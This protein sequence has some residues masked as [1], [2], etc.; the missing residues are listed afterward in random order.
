M[1]YI[2][3]GPEQARRAKRI[4]A[5]LESYL[6][7]TEVHTVE[8]LPK[9]TS[10]DTLIILPGTSGELHLSEGAIFW[11]ETAFGENEQALLL[12][13][14]DL[15]IAQRSVA[16]A[17]CSLAEDQTVHRLCAPETFSDDRNAKGEGDPCPDE[18]VAEEGWEA[19]E[20][21]LR[22]RLRSGSL[23]WRMSTTP[24]WLLFSADLVLILYS[25][26]GDK[27]FFTAFLSEKAQMDHFLQTL[28]LYGCILPL[29]GYFSLHTHNVLLRIRGKQR[30][31]F[32]LLATVG[33]LS[34]A[35][36]YIPEFRAILHSESSV[37]DIIFAAWL[38]SRPTA[39]TLAIHL[40]TEETDQN[41]VC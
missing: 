6:Y 29:F 10:A 27:H 4:H 39:A 18:N 24:I 23:P 37:Y 26:I 22:A 7:K 12:A 21:A 5:F 20:R 40:L 25:L 36:A 9:K 1:I 38:I 13:E 28:C 19:R 3:H 35:A 33:V 2:V 31:P 17:R 11:N 14:V 16:H 41:G 32:V 30:P 15:R 8:S 34:L